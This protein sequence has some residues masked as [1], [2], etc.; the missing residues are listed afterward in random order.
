MPEFRSGIRSALL[1]AILI[2]ADFR[3]EKL[4]KE[5]A[6]KLPVFTHYAI[7]HFWGFNLPLYKSGILQLLK[8]LAHC[9][10]CDGQLLVDVAE[11][12]SLLF[13]EEFQ[14]GNAGWVSQSLGKPCQG[15]GLDAICF[16]F[17]HNQ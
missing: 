12:T 15:L 5:L 16:L 1:A 4:G 8:V 7:F 3:L 11:I 10:L 6:G 9:G 13:G 2:L 14:D 17:D